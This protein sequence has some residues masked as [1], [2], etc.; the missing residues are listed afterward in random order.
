[1]TYALRSF[2]YWVVLVPPRVARH[3]RHEHRRPG[4][5]PHGARRRPRQAREPRPGCRRAVPRLRRAGHPRRDGDAACDVRV[6]V[7][8]DGRDPLDAPVRRDARDAVAHA[9]SARRPS[10]VRRARVAGVSAIYLAIIAAFGAIHSPYA[11][12][13]WPAAI[14]LG[15][16]HSAPVSA[17]SAWLDR[18]EGLQRAL[19]LRRHADVPLLGNVLPR[20]AAAAR[21]PAR[22]RTRRRCGTASP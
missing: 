18:E 19:P 9:R 1:M 15:L 5:V 16:A 3:R 14:L 6:V 10:A 8:R 21:V 20:D 12:L 4:A 2:E 22:S 13:A 7:S 17:F 11:I